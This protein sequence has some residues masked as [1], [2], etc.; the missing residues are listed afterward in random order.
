M[1]RI[2]VD[3]FTL[4]EP[5]LEVIVRPILVYLFLVIALRL[6]GKRELAQVNSFDLVV[7]LTI[8]NL[9][10]NAG[11]GSDTS[12]LAGWVSTA[13][14]LITNYLVVRLIFRH[15]KVGRIIE[16]S[17]RKL[18]EDGKVLFEN[19][20]K[21]MISYDDLIEA[22]HRQGVEQVHEVRRCEL[23]PDG[24]IAVFE[25]HPTELEMIESE[26]R[27][28]HQKLDELLR[29]LDGIEQRLAPTA[30]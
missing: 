13:A 23:D 14:L 10:Q 15:P 9:L 12:V 19:L 24:T 2:L 25:K 18:I 30:G 11:I 22:I 20:E 28:I 3:T 5:A 7:L 1:H 8:S 6:A 17:P 16:G 26:E 29:R 21:E 4:S 27:A